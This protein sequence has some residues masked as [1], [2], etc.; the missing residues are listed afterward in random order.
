MLCK[1]PN[2]N[3]N[4]AAYMYHFNTFLLLCEFL[5]SLLLAPNI[6]LFVTVIRGVIDKF[7]AWGGTQW[8]VPLWVIY[9]CV[10]QLFQWLC[11]KS[12]HFSKKKTFAGLGNFTV[13][14]AIQ[15]CRFE[16]IQHLPDSPD[17]ASSDLF[18]K[19]KTEL[20]GRHVITCMRHFLEIK[21]ANYYKSVNVGR[22]DL[23]WMC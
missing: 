4:P 16:L 12:E 9:A 1:I 23:K 17:V 13:M 3:P 14:A 19:M 6:S 18:H 11:R 20:I 10:V 7:V 5:F 22:D 21:A 8:V 2:P 15:E